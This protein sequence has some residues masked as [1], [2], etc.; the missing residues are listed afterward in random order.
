MAVSD[1]KMSRLLL[2]WVLLLLELVKD[3]GRFIGSLTLL[4][5]GHKP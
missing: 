5:T 1:G 2:F 3:T 4:D